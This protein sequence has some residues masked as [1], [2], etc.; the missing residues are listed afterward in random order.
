MDSSTRL[1]RIGRRTAA[2]WRT[3]ASRRKPAVTSSASA[4]TVP[5]VK[6]SRRC[7]VPERAA[8][9]TCPPGRR[10]GRAS[11][12]FVRSTSRR[13]GASTSRTRTELA[14]TK[15]CR[16]GLARGT[17]RRSGRPAGSASS[18]LAP[19]SA[20]ARAPYSRCAWTGLVCTESRP[21]R[22]TRAAP[23][24]GRR[25]GAGSWSRTTSRV[26]LRRPSGSC[27][28]TARIATPSRR[29]PAES[30]GKAG[31]SRRMASG[32]WSSR[33]RRSLC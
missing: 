20:G 5:T 26:M 2:G 8:P 11:P 16:P 30:H 28:R 10:T 32:S 23:S 14:R 19:T 6:T 3:N 12:T 21:G 17:T 13:D 31:L 18:L 33:T 7:R 9:N 25:T 1:R 27:I 4:E 24:T 15:L 22:W 29:P